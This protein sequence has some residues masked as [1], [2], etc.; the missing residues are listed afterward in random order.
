M[1]ELQIKSEKESLKSLLD[2]WWSVFRS[3][4]MQV[5]R[6]GGTALYVRTNVVLLVVLAHV[7]FGSAENV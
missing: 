4:I 2:Q 7:A 6:A 3:N 1:N 5:V